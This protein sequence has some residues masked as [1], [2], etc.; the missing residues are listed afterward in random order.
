MFADVA[1]LRRWLAK[2]LMAP[3]VEALVEER[4]RNALQTLDDEFWR[5]I[6]PPADGPRPWH[7]TRQLLERAQAAYESNPI[8][9][10]IIHMTTDFVIGS[11]ATIKG[12]AW[13][14]AFWEHPQNR[15]SERIYA[16]CDELA[17]SGELFIV[18]SRNRA[19]G[20]SYVREIPAL[21]IDAIECATEDRELPLRY[22]QLTG[23]IEGRWW[24][25]AQAAALSTED[26][27]QVMVHYAINRPLGGVRGRSDLAPILVW[28][29]RYAL[30]LE[31]RVRINRGKSAFLWHV[32]LENAQPSQLEAKRHQY[33]RV[34]RPGSIIISDTS[35]QWEAVSPRIQ[36]DDAEADGRALRLMIAAGA[37]VPLHYL[38]EAEG[39]NR[40]TAR[41]MA[42]PALRRFA[43]RQFLFATFLENLLRT[44][45]RRAGQGEIPLRVT[46]PS[47]WDEEQR[48]A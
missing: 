36:A 30:W 8:A 38:G 1:R 31:D 4:V 43:H 44:A 39:T 15:L 9:A 41:E 27:D 32:R 42:T 19:D 7:E 14:H 28:L 35:E 11:G 34:P 40:A 12:P 5:P 20:M 47:V 25:S 21:Q 10:R 26:P 2:R 18:L 17:L 29:E 33:S 24:P 6:A 13:V 48:T 23:D 46:F 37:G 45:A 22:H 16:W 3:Q